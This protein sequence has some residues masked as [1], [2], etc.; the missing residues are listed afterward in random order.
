MQPCTHFSVTKNS[1]LRHAIHGFDSLAAPE[2]QNHCLGGH[3]GVA[4][5]SDRPTPLTCAPGCGPSIDRRGLA[6]NEQP[7]AM[8][9]RCRKQLLA[10]AAA[11]TS[12]AAGRRSRSE[13]KKPS[14]GTTPPGR[15]AK[16]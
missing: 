9:H 6:N 11:P 12:V 5:E 15:A 1:A 14:S 7:R 8:W 3:N 13:E 16:H 4:G 2:L 10:A